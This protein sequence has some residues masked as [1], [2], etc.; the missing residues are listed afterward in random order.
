M[1]PSNPRQP[2][3]TCICGA[4]NESTNSRCVSCQGPASKAEI[5]PFEFP[6]TGQQVR[7]VLRDAEPWFVAVDVCAV[8]GI[9]NPSD[10]VRSLDDDEVELV[11][12]A[13]VIA[14]GRPQD[15]L[16][17][18]T[19]SGLYSLI[20]RSRKPEARAF[21]RWVTHEVLPAI[22][23]TGSYVAADAYEVPR[24]LPEAL[25]AYATEVEAHDVTKA[26]LTE[27]LPA[28]DAWN[29]LADAQGDYS[30]REAAQILNRDPL[31][32]TGQN[33]LSTYLQTIGWTDSTKQPYQ[34]HVDNGRLVRRPTSYEHP[35]TKE[36]AASWQVRITAKGLKDLRPRM[37]GQQGL[38]TIAEGA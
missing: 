36:R 15:R 5:T 28:A 6:I 23:R 19:E 17:L 35:N 29:V 30:L 12:A 7:T 31:I 34:T 21:K 4:W 24:S 38:L 8:L 32:K 16:N 1:S 10:A 22:R 14:E 26:A 18:I 25:R 20:L 3:W 37:A 27:A 9:A 33:R 11:P 2:G 13:L